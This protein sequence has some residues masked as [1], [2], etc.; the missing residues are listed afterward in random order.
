MMWNQRVENKKKSRLPVR[1]TIIHRRST[2]ATGTK[3]TYQPRLSLAEPGV[4]WN[5]PFTR[6]LPN[7]HAFPL[8]SRN[9]I[10]QFA[11]ACLNP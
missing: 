11:P 10:N 3:S 2:A 9:Q 6:H 4:E 7:G 1:A 8:P 5:E